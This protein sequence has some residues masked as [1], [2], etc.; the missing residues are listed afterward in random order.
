MSEPTRQD[1]LTN[2]HA[3]APFWRATPDLDVY[4]SG[5]EYLIVL[6]VPGAS[7]ESV[8]VQVVGT[9]LFV[10]AEQAAVAGGSGQGDADQNDI[11]LAA[12]ERQLELPAEVDSNSAVA[13]LR[14]GILEIRIQKSASARRVKIPVSAN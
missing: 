4:E 1:T 8:S 14:D 5:N 2:G 13:E 9:E 3:K 6:D 10:R 12:F 7:A 11:A